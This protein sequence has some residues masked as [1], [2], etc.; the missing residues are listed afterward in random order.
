MKG[1]G[2]AG[3]EYDWDTATERSDLEDDALIVEAGNGNLAVE[4]MSLLY[5]AGSTIDYKTSIIGSQFEIDNPMSKSSC[6]CGVSINID[7]DK[8]AEQEQILATELK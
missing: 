7:M 1:G 3:F 6:G 4:T 5:L 2:C 8:L